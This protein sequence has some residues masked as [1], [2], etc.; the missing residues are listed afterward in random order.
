MVSAAI[1]W[2]G[3]TKPFCVNENGI[4]VNKENYCKHFKKQLFPAIKKLVKHG[5]LIFV[6]DSA[7]S[8]RSNFVQDFLEK[9]LK[10]HFVKCVK[11]S[12]SLPDVNSLDYFLWDLVKTKVYQG[13]AGEPFSSEKELKRK[14]KAVWKDCAT[15]LKQLRKAIKQFVPRLRAVEE[16]QG[17]CIKMIFC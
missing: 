9:I 13:R 4:K 5:G 8:H 14:I 10:C 2:Y 15:D 12:R 7:P 6:Q 16:K 17:Y 11:W 1:S 3:A